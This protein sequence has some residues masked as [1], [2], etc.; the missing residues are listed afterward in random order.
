MADLVEY[1]IDG[2]L[3]REQMQK[4]AKMQQNANVRAASAQPAADQ[5]NSFHR[6]MTSQTEPS[7]EK[8]D[9]ALWE[10]SRQFEAIFVQQMMTEMR[11]TVSKSEF[12]PSGYAEDVHASM[13][14]E[15]IAQANSKRS[16]FGIADNIYRQLEAAQNNRANAVQKETPDIQEISNTADNLEM[17]SGSLA[18][19]VGKHAY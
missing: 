19:G 18:I 8:K 9:E 14:D 15:A 3:Q 2:I 13:M 5:E 12:M 17:D 6:I 1:V 11:K 7:I 10:V 16:S 4:H